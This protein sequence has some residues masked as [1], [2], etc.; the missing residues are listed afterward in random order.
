MRK[1]S[2]VWTQA[3]AV[4]TPETGGSAGNRS[5][6][7]PEQSVRLNEIHRPALLGVPPRWNPGQGEPGYGGGDRSALRSMLATF[8]HIFGQMPPGL[9]ARM[10][11][12][13]Q[14]GVQFAHAEGGMFKTFH[15]AVRYPGRSVQLFCSR[16]R[17]VRESPGTWSAVSAC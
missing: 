16:R 13:D 8:L 2:L 4:R 10:Q 11:Q 7:E 12:N 9:T 3:L 5:K 1:A 6:T 17:H 14:S 15:L